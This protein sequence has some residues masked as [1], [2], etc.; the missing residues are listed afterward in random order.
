M[1]LTRRLAGGRLSHLGE[2][3]GEYLWLGQA[4]RQWY[5][6]DCILVMLSTM[7]DL[8][9]MDGTPKLSLDILPERVPEEVFRFVVRQGSEWDA[10]VAILAS[11]MHLGLRLPAT[12]YRAV[13]DTPTIGG[14]SRVLTGVTLPGTPLLIEGSN[15]EVAWGFTNSCGDT[16][17]G[18]FRRLWA[19]P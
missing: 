2:R 10:A 12:W 7:C 11:D 15:G 17:V 6:A 5:A 14:M 1:D 9:A 13:M 16:S 8:Q 19:N 18:Y 3:P 4:P